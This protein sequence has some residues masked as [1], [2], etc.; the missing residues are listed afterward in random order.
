MIKQ[1]VPQ[2]A[3]LECR[4]CCRF[5]EEDS[6]WV[7][8]LLNEEIAHFLNQGAAA[9]LIT[10]RKKLKIVPFPKQ[11]AYLCP[12]FKYEDNKCKI[13][14]SRPLECQLYPFLICAKEG[15]GGEGVNKTNAGAGRMRKIY[16]AADSNCPFLKEKNNTPDFKEYTRYLVSLLQNPP[17]AELLRNNPHIAQSYA[18]VSQIQEISL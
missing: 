11:K 9:A 2:K 8:A 17:Y 12:L 3:C 18:E 16:L 5:A 7:P 10:P 1:F 14:D 15:S 4:G 13:Y 6:A